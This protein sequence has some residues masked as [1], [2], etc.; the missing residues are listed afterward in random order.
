MSLLSNF[1]KTLSSN[2]AGKALKGAS[3]ALEAAGRVVKA[4][5]QVSEIELKRSWRAFRGQM[6]KLA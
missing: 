5:R 2:G 3:E 1:E 4:M 6:M